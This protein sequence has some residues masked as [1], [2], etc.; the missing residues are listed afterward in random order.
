MQIIPEI[1]IR[2]NLRREIESLRGRSFPGLLVDQSYYKQLPH[3]RAVVYMK[4]DL[5]AYMAL[6]YR[7]ISIDERPYKVLV[8]IDFCIDPSYRGIGIGARM[9]NDLVSSTKGNSIDFVIL[10]A[11]ESE[12]YT[13]EGFRCC[14]STGSWLEIDKHKNHGVTGGEIS[15]LYVKQVGSKPWREGHIDWLGYM[16]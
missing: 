15:D 8:V 3:Y 1:N 14:K 6:D 7:V 13:C 10:V 12:F 2:D 11:H 16:F 5:C 9:L 4:N